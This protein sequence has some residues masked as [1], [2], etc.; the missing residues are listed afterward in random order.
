MK[1]TNLIQMLSIFTLGLLV[2][3]CA[4]SGNSDGNQDSSGNPVKNP[5]LKHPGNRKYRAGHRDG[6]TVFLYA[7]NPVDHLYYVLFAQRKTGAKEWTTPGGLVDPGQ[8]FADAAARELY[9]ETV[10]FYGF[11]SSSGHA[12]TH[13][14]I[15]AGDLL[16]GL[17][18]E[19][20]GNK[21]KDIHMLFFAKASSMAP[22][23]TIT[24]ALATPGLSHKY[25]EMQ[26]YKWVPLS[27]LKTAVNAIPKAPNGY[28]TFAT[29]PIN[30][31]DATA[32][33]QNITIWAA[34][35]KSLT[36]NKARTILSS[37]P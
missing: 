36:S 24:A 19:I 32:G 8:T 18:S 34:A 12:G 11:D 7:E 1:K 31:V 23:L 9:E 4:G 29:T 33:P 37:L 5:T 15:T 30:W 17:Y 13:Q 10:K 14:S 25:T 22:A 21:S 27:V 3:G 20:I 2:I 6:S 26:D 35:I 16:T 28:G